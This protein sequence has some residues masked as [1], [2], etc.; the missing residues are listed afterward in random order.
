MKINND[1]H[2]VEIPEEGLFKNLFDIEIKLNMPVTRINPEKK[3]IIAADGQAYP[4]DKL[5]L[6]TVQHQ[7]GR[8]MQRRKQEKK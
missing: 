1:Y 6:S 5:V 7:Y 3:E 2:I 8:E 4:Y